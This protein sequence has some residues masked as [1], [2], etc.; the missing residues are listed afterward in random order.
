ME[1]THA[2]PECITKDAPLAP[3]TTLGIGGSAEYLA[4][5]T[6][7]DE[8]GSVVAWAKEQEL[9]LTVLGGGSN[10]LI[11]DTGIRGVVLSMCMRGISYEKGEEGKV[12][13]EVAAGEVWDSFVEDAARRGYWGVENLSGIPG[14]VGA[15]PVQNINA[16]GVSVGDVIVSVQAY[17][18][19]EGKF[20]TLPHDA[21]RFA[22]RD[23]LFKT[24]EGTKYIITGV[25]F[26]LTTER[27]L[28]TSYRSSSQSIERRL[29]DAGIDT[30]S[31]LDL[32]EAVLAVRRNIGMLLGMYRSA[33]SFFKNTIVSREEFLTIKAKVLEEHA[34]KNA[35]LSPWYWEMPDG[36]VKVSTA[37]LMECT[38]YNKT[39]FKGKTFRGTVG[40]SPL[41]TLSLINAGGAH[42]EDVH[43]FV[44]EITRTIEK[45]FGVRIEP[46]V[47]YLS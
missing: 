37:F 22:Y 29:K 12:L 8:L 6:N 38:P 5:V 14:K 46:E 19:R 17:D 32:R 40:I 39:D 15:A 43:A 36:M 1:T 42:A 7:P 28:Q 16:Y 47:C 18:T 34:E 25:T 27:A 3:Y 10:V 45:E 44:E 21:C 30:P 35:V 13:A 4:T 24:D 33:G 2:M 9:P 20:V 31:P 26:T 11:A 41:H 23:S